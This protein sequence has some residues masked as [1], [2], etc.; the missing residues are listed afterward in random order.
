[1]DFLLISLGTGWDFRSCQRKRTTNKVHPG[2][3]LEWLRGCSHQSI[4]SQFL[5]YSTKAK[6]KSLR[7]QHKDLIRT[8]KRLQVPFCEFQQQIP[9]RCPVSK[10]DEKWP[11]RVQGG[12]G[13]QYWTSP[14]ALDPRILFSSP[15]YS[16]TL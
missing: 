7:D 2:D 12:P 10:Q 3:R 1:M 11:H 15:L 16:D 5:F 14:R 4:G 8:E 6:F 13:A 9:G